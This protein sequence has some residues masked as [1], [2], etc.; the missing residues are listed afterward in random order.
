MEEEPRKP[1]TIDNRPIGPPQVKEN[2]TVFAPLRDPNDASKGISQYPHLRVNN[3]GS[4]HM[5]DLVQHNNQNM[6]QGFVRMKQ[7]SRSLPDMK[8]KTVDK[9]TKVST[10]GNQ[11]VTR[12]DNSPLSPNG[13]VSPR[14]QSNNAARFNIT[15]E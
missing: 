1:A 4:M 8:D 3:D 12:Q 14:T 10:A 2:F 6:G 15:F 9:R 5:S 13:S 7:I 11:I